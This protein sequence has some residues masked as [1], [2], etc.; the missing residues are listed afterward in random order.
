[1]EDDGVV[2]K[3]VGPVM[4]KQ[5]LSQAKDNVAKRLEF[6]TGDLERAAK[7]C[8]ELEKGLEDQ[9]DKIV[10]IQQGGAAA[11]AASKKAAEDEDEE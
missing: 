8:D 9:K 11:A 5:D 1:M 6:I 4:V 2:Y 10:Q 7:M 3:L